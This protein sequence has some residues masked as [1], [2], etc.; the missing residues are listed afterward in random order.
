MNKHKITAKSL[1]SKK[2][3]HL[4]C[5]IFSIN[6][7]DIS[8]IKYSGALKTTFSVKSK[9]GFSER[10]CEKI[11]CE[12]GRKQA[13]HT[14]EKWIEILRSK[15]S[16]KQPSS[17]TDKVSSN[18]TTTD[19]LTTYQ[20]QQRCIE[21]EN[22][23]YSRATE[24]DLWQG[25]DKQTFEKYANEANTVVYEAPLSDFPKT[26]EIE[27]AFVQ[28]L[29]KGFANNQ[30]YDKRSLEK[31]GKSLGITNITIVKELTEYAIV[32]Y[33]RQIAAQPNLSDREKY[34]L[35]VE[36]YYE[37]PNLSLRTSESV[38]MQQY[39]TPSPIAF[40][41][42]MFTEASKAQNVFEPSAGNGL[43]VFT[44]KPENTIVNELDDIRRANLLKQ[45]Y[46]EVMSQDA[47]LPFTTLYRTQDVVHTNPPFGTVDKDDIQNFD[48]YKIQSLEH[49]MAIRAL[50]TMK[51]DGKAVIIVGGH[52][53]YDD[54]NRVKA[55][56]NRLF[57]N[58][59]YS[60]YYV[61]DVININ[62]KKLYSRMGTG[63]DVRLILIEGRKPTIEGN[64]PLKSTKDNIV[65]S[66]DELFERVQE[67]MNLKQKQK[68]MKNNTKNKPK[69]KIGDTVYFFSEQ[70]LDE[71]KDFIDVYVRGRVQSISYDEIR[72]MYLYYCYFEDGS[73]NEHDEVDLFFENE[74]NP[75]VTIYEGDKVRKLDYN[76]DTK[77]LKP[78]IVSPRFSANI[79]ENEQ[80]RQS[81]SENNEQVVPVNPNVLE[82]DDVDAETA[83]TPSS[84]TCVTLNT[85]VPA[86]MHFEI[87]EAV[88][89]VR[90]EIGDFNDYLIE[91]LAFKD[92]SELCE[93]LAAE[94]I[95]SVV[96]AIYNI[97]KKSQGVIIG[98]Q[99]G[100]GK[101]RIAAAMLRYAKLVGKKPIFFTIQPNLFSD[102]YRDLKALGMDTLVPEK[103]RTN[104]DKTFRPFIL[105]AKG[106]VD[107][108]VKNELGEVVYPA[109]SPEESKRVL[110]TQDLSNYDCVLTTYSQVSSNQMTDKK[111]F[112]LS[113]AK[114]NIIVMDESHKA[115]GASNTG[116][117]LQRVLQN[118]KGVTFLSATFAKR[119]ENMPIYAQKT[120]MSDANLKSE[121]LITAI[122]RGGEAL[123]E[124]ISSQLVSEAQMIRLESSFEGVE[125]NYINLDSTATNWQLDDK[126][127]IHKVIYDNIIELIRDVINFQ[128]DY[129]D[130]IVEQMDESA[131]QSAE[132]ITTRKGVETAGVDNYP[133][134]NKIFQLVFQMLFAIKAEAVADR[135]IIRM[136]EGKKPIIAFTS[137]MGSFLENLEDEQTGM[138]IGDGSKIKTDFSEIVQRLLDGVLRYTE[139]NTNGQK[140]H[141]SFDPMF[142]LGEEAAS[143]YKR[144]SSKIKNNV[145]GITFSPIDLILKKIRNAGFSVAEVTG[146]KY[147]IDLDDSFVGIGT[148]LRRK[149]LNTNDA[150]LKFQNNE[151]DCL[152]INTAGATGASAH[153]IPTALVPPE[154]VKQRVMII[155]QA[156]LDINTEVQKRGRINRTGQLKHIP[157]IYEYVT[158]SIP[159]EKR[160]MM[161]LQKKLKSLDANTSS[162]QKNSKA[163][164]DT[165]DFLNKYGDEVVVE[166]LKE[167][168]EINSK[169]G[170]PLK[171]KD[172]K[173]TNTKKDDEEELSTNGEVVHKVSG[174]VAVLSVEEQERFYKEIGERYIDLIEYL[175]QTGEYD[176]EVEAMNLQAQKISSQVIIAGQGNSSFA[177]ASILNKY[178]V[179]NLKKPYKK[180]ELTQLINA[181]LNGKTPSEVKKDLFSQCETHFTNKIMLMRKQIRE[182]YTKLIDEVENDKDARVKKKIKS[183]TFNEII[184]YKKELIEGL[185][186]AQN[187]EIELEQEKSLA[188]QKMIGE[189]IS[190]LTIGDVFRY[191][192]NSSGNI[193]E[194]MP[195]AVFLGFR[196]NKN[197]N[198]PFAPSAIKARFAI[199]NSSKYVEFSLSSK[200]VKSIDRMFGVS[201][202]LT[203]AKKKEVL[204]N[205]DDYCKQSMADRV[206]RY[207]IT[208]NILQ[209]Y[210]NPAY[211]G[212]FVSF[213]TAD[214]EIEKGILLPE[215]FGTAQDDI[216]DKIKVPIIQC[217]D[218]I[219]NLPTGQAKKTD[220]DISIVSQFNNFSIYLPNDKAYF[221]NESLLNLLKKHDEQERGFVKV[222]NRYKATISKELIDE[223]VEIIDKEFRSSIEI[224]NNEA[225]QIGLN[226]EEDI[227]SDPAISALAKAVV[228]GNVVRIVEK[229]PRELY[230]EVNKRLEGIGGIWDKEK[231]GHV[232]P[233]DP[234]P[235]LKS[236]LES[237]TSINLKKDYQFFPTPLALAK[238][239]IELAN[240]KEG[241][242][243]LEPSA[244]NGVILELIP[245]YADV[246]FCEI[247]PQN[248]EVLQR[249]G[250][251]SD[252]LDFLQLDKPNYF[253][254]I[255]ANPPFRNNQ[256]IDH[257]Y[258]MW[259]VL[260]EGGRIVVIT[261]TSW[262]FGNQRKQKEFR[263]WLEQVGA[264]Q[265]QIPEGTFKESGTNIKTMLLV[266]DKPF[267]S[268]VKENALSERELLQFKLEIAKE[269]LEEDPENEFLQF[270]VE[271]AQEMLNELN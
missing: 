72:K 230:L 114:N 162:N 29:L 237:Q 27:T 227:G 28:T 130:P 56:K 181:S 126:S 120:A 242:K 37:Q 166:W 137:T 182:K 190:D 103:K 10:V 270:K 175:K 189:Y 125:V 246:Y 193:G 32:Q 168:P 187:D 266:I 88:N 218:L 249:K 235:L 188:L 12:F 118:A 69:F 53:K 76:L 259:E 91:K 167:N 263:D 144:I 35:I 26:Q 250:Y 223:F 256:D 100:I 113:I 50:E 89:K 165:T 222:S 229:L 141:K 178:E 220:D 11:N 132:E 140:I 219:K 200:F 135:A 213:T 62:G 233:H 2:L 80:T 87:H 21:G 106:Q 236:L 224:T 191:P 260:K 146:R 78:L 24:S 108:S 63:F 45:G 225:R 58:Y 7:S 70:G 253:D 20:Y 176:L 25:I 265:E 122:T 127:Q 96:L 65:N 172:G 226:L 267:K 31:L 86:F 203:D 104:Q 4:F 44:S 184:A 66:F 180:I 164:L 215:T 124:I 90:E 59:L 33:V 257:V 55:G 211:R 3:H 110:T 169:I 23:Y 15:D 139:T 192:I 99:T 34:D 57:L 14:P 81:S 67:A 38:L 145:S 251:K 208:G 156:E 197:A 148:V 43:L 17:T 5:D 47:T 48:G 52:T 107:P 85:K 94:Q 216:T 241:D 131:A 258:K 268:V 195:Y 121:E 209:A 1:T 116:V 159:A 239:M 160:L 177:K 183:G 158:S 136:K 179:N 142:E 149:R 143:E 19:I 92:N 151:V 212:K 101:G 155:L 150:Y 152:L 221:T 261:S 112:L 228:S 240:I 95:D 163:I 154:K 248:N 79:Q 61:A 186:K 201:R 153:A 185:I 84:D 97:E 102:I 41:A 93:A 49:I 115:S 8:V 196:I 119:P 247:M 22:C 68:A 234:R 134:F 42:G 204:E 262:T 231:Q 269:M 254:K 238:R 105:N 217:I 117:F 30:K 194:N 244:G 138:L 147:E 109:L 13:T 245:S 171:L 198:N 16:N 129:V 264:T 6:F 111:A 214:G 173:D 243:V 210:G 206:N 64:A 60:H 161:M 46:K 170:D 123:Q 232:F 133:V 39:S 199:S 74:L 75:D 36:F 205:W 207:I 18:E 40:V 98:H 9:V 51:D 252:C 174:R 202:N 82:A 128:K 73:N 157:P 77:D 71:N 83:Y 54:K 255:I 271:I